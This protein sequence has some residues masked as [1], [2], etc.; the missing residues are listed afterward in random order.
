M[1]VISLLLVAAA[2]S[3]Y[4]GQPT[5]PNPCQA[6]GSGEVAAKV[7]SLSGQVSVLHDSQPWALN[8]GDTVQSK[9]VIISGTDG[10]AVFCVSDGSTFEVFPNSEVVF[11]DN[12]PNWRDM[13]DVL[14][15][16][17]RVQIQKLGGPNPNR[18]QTPT[19][20]ISVRGTIFDVTVDDEERTTVV[21]VEEGQVEVRHRLIPGSNPKLVKAG[22]T[23]K[24][25]P[26]EPLSKSRLDKGAAAQRV[27]R[28]MM[29]AVYT[30]VSSPRG[31]TS[32]GNGGTT[33]PP[34][35]CGAA[36]VGQ[37]AP[38]PPPPPPPPPPGG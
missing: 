37:K 9:Q 13:L 35:T 31:G 6:P 27:L 29:D 11:R 7:V 24:V 5:P 22:E 32:G 15:G 10:N 16:R 3:L 20:T 12:P 19:A 25:Y 30:A 23:L 34:V 26:D 2:V 18:V 28:A 21:A 14:V 8:V 4:A 33:T 36:C 1:P 17:I 38:A